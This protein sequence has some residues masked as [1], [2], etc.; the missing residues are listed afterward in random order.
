[1]ITYHC[2]LW[3]AMVAAGLPIPFLVLMA[4]VPE[5]PRYAIRSSFPVTHATR[6][7]LKGE[8]G[9]TERYKLKY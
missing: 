8:A 3:L 2:D 7:T 9:D 4:Y 6:L 1:M 5:T